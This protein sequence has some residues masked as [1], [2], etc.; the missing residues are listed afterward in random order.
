MQVDLPVVRSSTI[1]SLFQRVLQLYPHL[2]EEPTEGCDPSA[3][4]AVDPS[5]D[6]S[7]DPSVDG[8]AVAAALPESRVL[9]LAKGFSTGPP[10]SLKGALKLKWNDAAVVSQPDAALDKPPLVCGRVGCVAWLLFVDCVSVCIY[11]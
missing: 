8:A 10:L 11:L 7:V 5:A 6:P 4:P 9:S 2:D 3:D 1:R